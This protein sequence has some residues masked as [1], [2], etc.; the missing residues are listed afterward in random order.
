M[1]YR[2]D[3]EGGM[4][5]QAIKGRLE[6][7]CGLDGTR[8]TGHLHVQKQIKEESSLDASISERISILEDSNTV[9]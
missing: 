8:R 6:G 2:G 7:R 4:P 1:Q 9:S 3:K 5:V